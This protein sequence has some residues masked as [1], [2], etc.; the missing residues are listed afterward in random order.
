MRGTVGIA[1]RLGLS[2]L[3]IGLT[4]VGFGTSTP[5][6]VT[7]L[8]AALREAPG[9]ALGNVIGSNVANILLILGLVTLVRPIAANATAVGRDGTLVI[10]VSI[11]LAALAFAYG[12]V[13][14]QQGA[15]LTALLVAYIGLIWLLESRAHRRAAAAEPRPEEP[16]P[17]S[18]WPAAVYALGGLAFLIVGADLLVQGAVTTARVAGIS[19]TVIGLT[20]VAVGTSL[21]ELFASLAAAVRGRGDIALGNIV[22]SNIYNI[23][24]VLGVTALVHPVA[25]AADVGVVDWAALVGSAVLL[26]AFARSGARISRA[27][28]AVFVALYA[29]YAGYLFAREGLI[30]GLPF[31]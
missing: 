12:E 10:L 8:D 25:I 21:P 7:S 27:E 11:L 26:V 20:V 3:V 23:L 31:G 1:R 28:G 17:A 19:E 4:L 15:I 14:R 9:I 30:P 16:A 22:G 29:A 6:L 24:G 18:L 5:E 2:E 13:T